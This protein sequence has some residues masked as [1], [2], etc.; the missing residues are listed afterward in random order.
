MELQKVNESLS[1]ENYQL[2]DY[3]RNAQQFLGQ[4]R[5][6]SPVH[7][8]HLAMVG[9]PGVNGR[10]EPEAYMITQRSEVMAEQNP[11]RPQMGGQRLSPRRVLAEQQ[12][13]NGQT[14]LTQRG[15]GRLALQVPEQCA[16]KTKF[17][18]TERSPGE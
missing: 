10:A 6:E 4:M 16:N 17:P 11:Y 9:Q 3:M 2:R 12:R 5:L 15:H 1:K 7:D 14:P 13:P 18:L 8:R